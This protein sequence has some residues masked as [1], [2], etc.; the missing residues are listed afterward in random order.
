MVNTIKAHNSIL[1][2]LLLDETPK[3]EIFIRENG[4]FNHQGVEK[5]AHKLV[6]RAILAFFHSR[7]MG[8]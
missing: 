1:G 3:H 8:K 5:P 4:V 6:T 2:T 7:N